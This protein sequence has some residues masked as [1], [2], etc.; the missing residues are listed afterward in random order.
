MKRKESKNVNLKKLCFVMN[1]NRKK[2]NH[3]KNCLC[4]TVTK[5]PGGGREAGGDGEGGL[6][7]LECEEAPLFMLLLARVV[8]ACWQRL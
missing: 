1:L 5:G 2:P 3:C 6:F 7:L 4:S 8:C